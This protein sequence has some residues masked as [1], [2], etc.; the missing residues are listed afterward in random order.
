MDGETQETVIILEG[1]AKHILK[2][3]KI[4]EPKLFSEKKLAVLITTYY[5]WTFSGS[6]R[7]Q[8]SLHSSSNIYLLMKDKVQEDTLDGT[9]TGLWSN[10]TL[11]LDS[12]TLL[13]NLF[14][15]F[16]LSRAISIENCSFPSMPMSSSV[17]FFSHVW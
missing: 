2:Y 7:I 12:V 14:R 8:Q 5:L 13:W 9:M 15:D 1:T 17:G 3:H 11:I 4:L 10:V 6:I 16:Q